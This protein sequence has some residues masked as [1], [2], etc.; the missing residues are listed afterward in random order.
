MVV[1]YCDIDLYGGGFGLVEMPQSAPKSNPTL[2]ARDLGLFPNHPIHNSFHFLSPFLQNLVQFPQ[3]L[4]HR[5]LSQ[6]NCYGLSCWATRGGVQ[7]QHR[8]SCTVS[9]ISFFSFFFGIASLPATQRQTPASSDNKISCK[10]LSCSDLFKSSRKYNWSCLD[11]SYAN[12][13]FISR[14]W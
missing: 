8:W 2:C 11:C 10:S 3:F 1:L 13:G 12:D 9:A 6:H 5:Y 14:F 4:H 7:K